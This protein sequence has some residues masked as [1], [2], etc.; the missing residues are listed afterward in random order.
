MLSDFSS[1]MKARCSALAFLACLALL[2]TTTLANAQ[3]PPR[4]I[5]PTGDAAKLDP[6]LNGVLAQVKTASK[7]SALSSKL[8]KVNDGG[9]VQVYVVVNDLGDAALQDLAAG[10]LKVEIINR[11]LKTVQGWLPASALAAVAAKSY[12]ERVTTP[13]YPKPRAG[14]VM[15]EGDAR[16]GTAFPRLA[17]ATGKGVKVGLIADG[18]DHRAAAIATG[19]LPASIQIDPS[20]PGQGDEGT[21]MLEIVHDIVPD[22]SLAFSGP[23]TSLEF[24]DSLDYLVNTAKCNVVFDDLAFY[25]ECYFQDSAFALAVT[26]AASKVVYVSAAGNDNGFHYQGTFADVDPDENGSDHWAHDLHLFAGTSDVSN[27]ILVPPHTDVAV[28]LQW[29]NPWGAA[30][31]D[32]D[33]YLYNQDLSQDLAASDFRQNGRNNPYEAL[34][35]TNNKSTTITVNILINR[36]SGNPCK[37]EMY[38]WGASEMQFVTPIDTIFGHAA[39]AGILSVGAVNWKTPKTI[40]PFSSQGPAVLMFPTPLV[41]GV[42]TVVAPDGVTVSGA[43]GFTKTF[44]GTSAAAAHTAGLAAMM[45]GADP[46]LTPVDVIYRVKTTAIDIAPGGYDYTFGRGLINYKAVLMPYNSIR[47]WQDFK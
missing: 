28:F 12:V 17:G 43:G 24:L 3:N 7:P 11:E 47:N 46:A 18:V 31:D 32:Y 22:A 9:A 15:T 25:D 21:A 40:E 10:G 2:S 1:K 6:L 23:R 42:P 39:A 26:A 44:Y 30:T 29:A 35:Y 34:I 20:H 41:R 5:K 16:I 37:M 45:L 19:D 33:L 13:S 36:Y 38:V 4:R 14:S 27:Q 8:L